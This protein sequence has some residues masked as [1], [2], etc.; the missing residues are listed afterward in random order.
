VRESN[1]DT[2]DSDCPIK[3]GGSILKICEQGD[4]TMNMSCFALICID[5]LENIPAFQ[6]LQLTLVYLMEARVLE[7][8]DESIFGQPFC[9]RQC[10]E[11]A[12]A[13]PQPWRSPWT[14]RSRIPCYKQRAAQN[15]VKCSEFDGLK[16]YYL[17]SANLGGICSLD[18]SAQYRAS[19]A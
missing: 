10:F 1:V 2:M 5:S 12:D 9:Q 19:K 7:C 4:A 8:T 18:V 6:S 15:G 16:T 13:T 14:R 3:V 11:T 17:S